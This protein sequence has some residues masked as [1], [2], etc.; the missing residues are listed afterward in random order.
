MPI[1]NEISEYLQKGRTRE[2]VARVQQALEEGIDPADIL[3]EGMLKGMAELGV[4][5]KKQ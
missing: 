4:R 5:F 1:L 2:V 3:N